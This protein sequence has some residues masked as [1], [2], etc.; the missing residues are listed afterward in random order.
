MTTPQSATDQ[1]VEQ[2]IAADG[3]VTIK[4]ASWDLDLRAGSDDRVRVRSASG[5]PL[6][7]GIHV[8][9]TADG[10]TI[11]QPSRLGFGISLGRGE[12]DL[13]LAIELP[14]GSGVNVT[15]ASGDVRAASLRGSQLY[16]TAS[17][18]VV[19]Q[20]VDGPVTAETV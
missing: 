6:P 1:I 7:S 17:G 4:T 10:V 2:P 11:R 18:D 16:R 12:T 19:L 15:T 8:D 14:A 3:T 5:G 9:R 20:A 13:A